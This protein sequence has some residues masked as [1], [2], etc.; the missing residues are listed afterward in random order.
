MAKPS[1]QRPP[2][3][4]RQHSVAYKK[5]PSPEISAPQAKTP[6]QVQFG[7]LVLAFTT[8][9]EYRWNDKGS[10]VKGD[11]AFWHP[12]PPA[13]FFALGTIG[14]TNYDLPDGKFAS[15]CVKAATTVGGKP[16]LAPPEGWT[17]IWNDK[18][19]PTHDDGSCWRPIAPEGYV[20]LGDV[21]V[22]GYDQPSG[23]QVMCVAKELVYE[24]R[25]G[26][27]IWAD[28]GSRAHLDFGA[29]Q[30]EAGQAF[31]DTPDGIFAVNS[32]VGRESHDKP[33]SSAVAWNLRLPLPTFEAGG[34]EKPVLTS[35]TKPAAHTNPVVDRIVTV[36]F[37]VLIDDNKPLQWRVENS[38]FY[39]VERSVDYALVLFI[40]N[41]TKTQ[42][43]AST[44]ITTG[45]S[46]EASHTFSVT[47]GITV[48]YEAGIEA[49]GS[50][51]KSSVSMSI[52]LGYSN[53]TSVTQFR[54]ETDQAVLVA[55]PDHAA[56]LWTESDSLR[57]R[58]ADGEA[59]GGPLSFDT[60]DTAYLVSEF[61]LSLEQGR[62]RA[63][64]MVSRSRRRLTL[65]GAL[66]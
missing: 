5:S 62:S 44:D 43:S 10:H 63:G 17:F 55:T 15:M 21:F 45:V 50:S 3:K 2:S 31:L 47:T 4:S 1:P 64:A 13:G 42:Q 66:H 49:G 11:V 9:Y 61:P 32:F 18:G 56:A 53:T 27:L 37:T 41:N 39:T 59:V 58:R 40:D 23:Q 33:E 36:P 8:A 52:E 20:A 57:V 28:G 51:T 25:I 26:D 16:A 65:P 60:T 22:R 30:I 19:S 6:S 34:P 29:W 14:V 54:S 35:R 24:G 48:S 12:K 38:P 7:E 46:R